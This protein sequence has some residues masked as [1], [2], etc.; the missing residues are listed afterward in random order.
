VSFDIF[1][2]SFRDGDGSTGDGDAA[3]RIL[4]PVIVQREIGWARIVTADGEADVYGIDDAANGLMVN[5][6]SGDA[7]YGFLYDVA[8]SAGFV[9]MPVGCP[10]CVVDPA[11]KAHLPSEIAQHAVVIESGDD[12]RRIIVNG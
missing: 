12:L 10:T 2:K 7:V 8:R 5:H 1:L 3:L 6:A 4:D 9:V 11:M